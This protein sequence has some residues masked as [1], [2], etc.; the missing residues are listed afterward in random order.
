MLKTPKAVV[1]PKIFYLPFTYR[2]GTYVTSL[3]II[4]RESIMFCTA[5][6]AFLAHNIQFTRALAGLNVTVLADRA[7]RVT[8]AGL[9][10]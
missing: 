5:L 10:L 6:V 9:K 7:F 2:I 3:S 8:V 1:I 4:H